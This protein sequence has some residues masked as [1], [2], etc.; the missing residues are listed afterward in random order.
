MSGCRGTCQTLAVSSMKTFFAFFGKFMKSKFSQS[1]FLSRELFTNLRQNYPEFYDGDEG[2]EIEYYYFSNRALCSILGAFGV[3][4]SLCCRVSKE[5]GKN[6]EEDLIF[7]IDLYVNPKL[8]NWFLSIVE[9]KEWRPQPTEWPFFFSGEVKTSEKK[10]NMFRM[11]DKATEHASG[12]NYSIQMNCAEYLKSA[13]SWLQQSD[14]DPKELLIPEQKSIFDP[15]Q[16]LIDFC[17]ERNITVQFGNY[18]DFE[19]DVKGFPLIFLILFL[20]FAFSFSL[21]FFFLFFLLVF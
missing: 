1:L 12:F 17:A 14:P 20:F 5:Q 15:D 16:P 18:A 11:L 4:A 8:K 13:I 21:F 19:R 9:E 2:C 7:R 6:A 10:W 3:H